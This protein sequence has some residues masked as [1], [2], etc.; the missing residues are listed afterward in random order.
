MRRLFEILANGDYEKG[1]KGCERSTFNH[2]TQRYY[3]F[4]SKERCKF[5]VPTA[6]GCAALFKEGPEA[7]ASKQLN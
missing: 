3:C 5:M 2:D 1:L 4:I 6:K 7:I